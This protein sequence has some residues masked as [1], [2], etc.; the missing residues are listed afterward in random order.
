ML[1]G[2][3]SQLH[4]TQVIPVL[5]SPPRICPALSMPPSKSSDIKM[6]PA[7]VPIM[8]QIHGEGLFADIVWE[9]KY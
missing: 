6:S 7:P 9:I 3:I 2:Q 8:A 1:L 4:V 5:L